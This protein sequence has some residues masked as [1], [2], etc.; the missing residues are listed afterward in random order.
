MKKQ[1]KTIGL[2]LFLFSCT[3]DDLIE[4][5]KVNDDCISGNQLI[6]EA[7]SF[8][9]NEVLPSVDTLELKGN[10][11]DEPRK[12]IKKTP[13]WDKAFIRDLSFGTGVVVP[14]IYEKELYVPRGIS[15]ISLSN[16]S[17]ILFYIDGESQMHAELV[18]TLPDENFMYS[19]DDSQPFSGLVI[20]ED[21][22]GNFIKGFLHKDGQITEIELHN[23]NKEIQNCTT[24][25]YYDCISDNG[26]LTWD[27]DLYDSQTICHSPIAGG[28]YEVDY[29]SSSTSSKRNLTPVEKAD[30]LNEKKDL[31]INWCPSQ[32]VINAVWSSLN[33]KIDPTL[34][35]PAGY[36][37]GSNTIVFRDASSITSVNLIEEAFH[38]FQN[39]YYPG[40]IS[41]YYKNPG[42]TN[43]EFEA[44][45]FKDVYQIYTNGGI[46]WSGSINFPLN[47]RRQYEALVWSIYDNGFT[48]SVLS[49]YS[50]VLN[51]FLKY[52]AYRSGIIDIFNTPKAFMNSKTNCN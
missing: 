21:W 32:M 19:I 30:L 8:F 17:Y 15:S 28:G 46:V 16:L 51:Y 3:N 37:P 34:S 4:N 18:T 38:A 10:N 12:K 36:L 29:P 1:L 5:N 49:Q 52:S 47:E 41:E 13:L 39:S 9:E 26:G 23:Y 7:Q 27:C 22:F 43:I 20:I 50:T 40:G 33:F 45:I 44:K 2:L 35:T 42:E 14:L 25:D 11:K 48:Q 6:F 24:T 31:L